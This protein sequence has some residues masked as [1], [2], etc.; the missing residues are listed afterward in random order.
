MNRVSKEE[1]FRVIGPLNVH[2]SIRPTK[3]PYTSDWKT[4]QGKLYGTSIDH[5][6]S[7]AIITDYY[8]VASINT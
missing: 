8:L 4:P 6:E 7:G 5:V 3:F 1:F 2:P